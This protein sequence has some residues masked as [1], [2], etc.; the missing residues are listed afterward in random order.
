MKGYALYLADT[1]LLEKLAI[2]EIGLSKTAGIMDEL[3]GLGSSITSEVSSVVGEKGIASTL[4]EYLATGVI[5]KLLGPWGAIISVAASILGFDIGSFVGSIIDFVKEKLSSG[6][7]ISLDD[8][9][10]KGKSLAETHAGSLTDE[11]SSTFASSDMLY[12]LKNAESEEKLMKLAAPSYLGL[13]NAKNPFFSSQKGLLGRLFGNLFSSRGIGGKSKILM[14]LAGIIVWVIKSVLLGA[15]VIGASKLINNHMNKDKPVDNINSD[16]S[17]ES[18]QVANFNIPS[19]IPN[20]FK[21]TGDGNQYHINDSSSMWIVPLLNN[22]VA[23]TLIW[24]TTSIYPELKG[25]ESE[26]SSSSSFN[27]MVSLLTTQI[28]P[29]HPGYVKIP[30]GLHTRKEV[31]DRFAGDVKLDNKDFK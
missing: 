5:M 2:M 29:T 20:S 22:D 6:Q 1:L 30:P 26:L 23:K 13:A 16:Q 25:H 18:T 4:E 17:N 24:W 31:I 14:I 7:S 9:N 21:S 8:I 27:N 3:G 11:S 19:A 10:S 28:D 15:G 12:F